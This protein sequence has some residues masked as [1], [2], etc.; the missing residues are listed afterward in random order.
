VVGIKSREVYE[1]PAATVLIGAH[2]A[3]EALVLPRDVLEFK[4][5]VE[6]RYAQLV[7]DGLWFSPLRSALDAFVTST[8]ERISGEVAMKLY[9]GNAKVSG[10]RSP[11]SIYQHS[12]ATYSSGDRF[13]QEMAEGFI[14]VWGLPARTW[15]AIGAAPTAAAARAAKYRA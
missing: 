13:R 6:Q 14:Y 7:Y 3:L 2:Q 8:Q 4:R 1:C 11:F 10:R 5:I 15:T 9:K 12:L